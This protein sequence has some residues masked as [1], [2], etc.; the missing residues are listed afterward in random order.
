MTQKESRT[1]YYSDATRPHRV[2]AM[3]D[4]VAYTTFNHDA[5]GNRTGKQ[6]QAQTY[7]YD[8]DDRLAGI[9]NSTVSFLYD[10]TGQK[11]AQV[12]GASVTRYY[13]KL[14]EVGDGYLTKHY[15]V[16]RAA[17]RLAA[18]GGAGRD[19]GAA[20]GPGGAGGRGVGHAA[21]AGYPAAAGPA[22][23][24]GA[25]AGRTESGFGAGAVAAK[26][27]GGDR[28]APGAGAAGADHVQR[29]HAPDTDLRAIGR[30]P[31]GHAHPDPN[32]DTDSHPDPNANAHTH[33]HGHADAK[34]PLSGSDQRKS[35]PD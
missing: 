12:Y 34:S 18:G 19:G 32:P 31:S 20:L 22:V 35:L 1:F 26:A 9:D 5:N 11:V 29:R 16:G 7:A 17:H 8:G 24:A 13:S 21:H 33:V 2:T 15:Y 4:G 30:G 10:Y 28:G 14:A 3:W 25:G 27:G 6:S 23:A